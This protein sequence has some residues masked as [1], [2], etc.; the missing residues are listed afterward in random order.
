MTQTLSVLKNRWVVSCLVALVLLRLLSLGM[1]PL[2]DT[3]EARYAEIARKMVELGNWITPW[4]DYGVP[5]WGKPPLSFWLTAASFKLFGVNEFAARLPH[6]V[7]GIV[8]V[9]LVWKTAAQRS[10]REALYSVVLLTGS[11]LFFLSAGM[12]MT[13]MAL[14]LS[15]VIAMRGCWLGLQ[16]TPEQKTRQ[17]WL[18]FVGLGLGLLAK[19]PVALILIGA[20]IALWSLASKSFLTVWRALPWVRGAALSAA[21]V[22]PWYIAAELR[23][24]GFLD[25][26]LIGEHWHRF[27]TPGWT[28]DLYGSAHEY[29]RG[30]IWLFALAD[31]L[32]WSL[33]LPA[34]AIVWHRDI[35]LVGH[36]RSDEGSWPIYLLCWGLMP[37]VFFTLAGNILWAY[38]LPGM[39]AL[40]LW[41]ATCLSR[42][43][44]QRVEKLL[45]LGLVITGL[46]Y[47]GFLINL[48]VADRDQYKSAKSLVAA[49]KARRH[50]DEPLVIIGGGRLYSAAFYSQGRAERL[51]RPDLL[52]RRLEE[53]P[54]MVAM[55]SEQMK[56][57]P[58]A[59][60]RMLMPV[61]QYGKF[62]L[63]ALKEKPDLGPL[64]AR[65]GR[66]D[67]SQETAS[68]A[69]LPQPDSR[70]SSG[71][72][73]MQNE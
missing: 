38:V 8:T 73:A 32:P 41:I 50:G 72:S 29:P 15:A 45:T 33:L 28:G 71:A 55:E 14:T 4:F 13:D 18:L 59:A 40:A 1:Y 30:T 56:N 6:W 16:G 66:N 42:L 63:L 57:L 26:F 70:R 31:W 67:S 68:Q 37:C 51:A 23:T 58:E 36:G 64:A 5:F 54:A 61:G 2:M 44:Q 17:R 69:L 48:R 35:R 52:L 62:A 21:I 20:P 9:W 47:A 25:Y 7:M 12:V 3:T 10:Q 34:A 19:G 53:G 27:V 46:G 11:G 60:G 43:P 22:F 49:Y 24:P 39:P 65:T